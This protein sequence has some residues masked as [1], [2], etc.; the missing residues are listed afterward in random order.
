MALTA[1][2]CEG[3]AVDVPMA[4]NALL[5]SD[6]N[7]LNVGPAA[8]LR[9][10]GCVAFGAGD[11]HMRTSEPKFRCGVI[12]TSDV[13]PPRC[14]VTAL[15]V[16]AELPFVLVPMASLTVTTQS[17]IRPAEVF[18][19]DTAARGLRYVLG[20]MTAVTGQTRMAALQEVPGFAVVEFARAD[21][22]ADGYE[23]HA[24]VLGVA[25]DAG[26]VAA[27]ANQGWMQSPIDREPLADF[28]VAGEA[29]ELCR[30]SACNVTTGALRRTFQ[31]V[32]RF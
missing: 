9:R 7:I 25:F 8:I 12:E 2:R 14:G 3:A 15:A 19:H 18:H 13:F 24:V 17:Q 30:T 32:M 16:S 11:L 28:S 1:R 4:G 23:V 31:C 5:K 29:L 6:A 26:V 22:P 27:P 20:I 21:V 10:H